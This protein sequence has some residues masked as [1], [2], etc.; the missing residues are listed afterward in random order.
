M[1]GTALAGG[2]TAY[3]LGAV[4][5]HLCCVKSAFLSGKSLVTMILELLLTE[6][7]YKTL[8]VGQK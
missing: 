5:N 4:I 6:Y 1:R 3:Y 7:S 2:Y 8:K